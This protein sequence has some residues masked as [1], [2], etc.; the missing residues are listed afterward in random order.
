MTDAGPKALDFAVLLSE[1]ESGSSGSIANVI[2]K[3]REHEVAAYN[4]GVGGPTGELVATFI[5]ALDAR[6]NER[7]VEIE[8]TCAY[9]YQSFVEA[10]RELLRIQNDASI[11]QNN[12]GAL[13]GRMESA[14]E[15]VGVVWNMPVISFL[16][17]Q[18]T[19]MKTDY[20]VLGYFFR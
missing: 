6:A 5:A 8:K 3:L 4:A 17:C 20:C 16:M 18:W 7:N 14:V 10:T 1:I 11:M 19:V 13:S 15:Q 2:R 12:I 9:H